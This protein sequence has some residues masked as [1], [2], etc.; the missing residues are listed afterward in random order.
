M[1]ITVN[2]AVTRYL[3]DTYSRLARASAQ[4]AAINRWRYCTLMEID[5]AAI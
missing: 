3:F 2:G 1:T 4:D 5:A